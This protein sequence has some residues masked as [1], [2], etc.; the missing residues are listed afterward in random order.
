VSAAT[1]T[2]RPTGVVGARTIAELVRAESRV[3]LR[4]PLL[5]LGAAVYGGTALLPAFTGQ[6]T[7][8]SAADLYMTY[9]FSSAALALA[10]FLVAVW[11]AARERPATTGEM[12]GNTPA[13]RWER[14]AGL[15]GA[16]IVPFVMA[17]VIGCVQLAVIQA[18]GG[19]PVG[20][21]PWQVD[22]V[23]TPLELLG[24]P[25]AVACSFV[26]GVAVVRLVR[27]RA[28][29]AVLGVVG[30]A[31]LFLFFWIWY[32][33]P[34]ALFA[35]Y[36]TA[37]T[38]QELTGEP[39]DAELSRF[40]AASVPDEFTRTYSGIDRDLG[41]YGLHLLFVVGLTVTL[42][43]IA[44]LRSGPDRRSWR[45]LTA[46]LL[47]GGVAVVAQLLWVDGATDWMGVL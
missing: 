34:F 24:A 20:H 22:L 11:A 35:V 41:F 8:D 10:A 30:A 9:Q 15:L 43:G 37:L 19:I 40:T 2:D 7:S 13:R 25:L 32:V 6:G 44:L 39:T 27:S 1:T 3:L 14:T 31:F 42:A 38:S 23:P 4:S 12:F 18:L 47:V 17:L 16:V 29:S 36:R 45:V 28:M 46:G 5:W 26:A 33:V 21:E